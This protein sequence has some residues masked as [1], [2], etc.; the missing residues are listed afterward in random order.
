MFTEE[1]SYISN[2]ITFIQWWFKNYPRLHQTSLR[3][4]FFLS[5]PAFP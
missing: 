4:K 3:T 5:K 2:I 1:G